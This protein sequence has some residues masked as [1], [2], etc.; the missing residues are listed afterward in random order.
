[1]SSF[2]P[3]QGHKTRTVT[4]KVHAQW[5]KGIITHGIVSMRDLI[6][7]TGNYIASLGPFEMKMLA[8][9]SWIHNRFIFLFN[10]AFASPLPGLWSRATPVSG[11]CSLGKTL[12][13]CPQGH[14]GRQAATAPCH[15][16]LASLGRQ[17][18]VEGSSRMWQFSE[19][20]PLKLSLLSMHWTHGQKAGSRSLL[21]LCHTQRWP[22]FDL[23]RKQ[24]QSQFYTNL[25][26]NWPF[27]FTGNPE[28]YKLAFIPHHQS[29][30]GFKTA[31][32]FRLLKDLFQD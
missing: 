11:S 24:I 8:Y 2:L 1:M 23:L 21:C 22:V 5:A 32:E 19:M 17:K 16:Q 18:R 6:T 29:T 10:E 12:P 27:P 14:N 9:A 31:R 13:G 20:P 30:L 3:R 7:A 4:S 15:A 28:V 26:V 25:L